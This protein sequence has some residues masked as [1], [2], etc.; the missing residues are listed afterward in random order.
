[1]TGITL[2][3]RS[4]RSV[5]TFVTVDN[6]LQ[7]VFVQTILLQ[8]GY[9]TFV[10]L[11][12]G[13]FCRLFI[14][15]TV[16]ERALLPKPTTTLGLVV[17]AFW[18]VPFLTKWVIAS[19]SKVILARPSWHS[20]AGTFT[21]GTS[22]PRW[23]SLILPHERIRRRIWWWTFPT[24]IDIVAETAIVSFHTLS[25]GFP[26]PTVSKNSL[27][28]LFCSLILD[29]GVLL[30]ISNSAPKILISNFLLHTSLHH[31]F[32]SVI[33][34][35]LTSS[36]ESPGRTIPIRSWVFQTLVFFIC[37]ILPRCHQVGFSS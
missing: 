10:I 24:L 32:Q 1:M 3:I 5:V 15:L 17:Q 37:T 2:D 7:Y 29:H 23:F 35:V 21:S 12:F 27:Y 4:L 8:H 36:D 26:L 14:N 19:S 25:V 22:G 28:T 6:R 33:I 13:P 34:K 16:C 30:K 11:R 20:T 9:C 31:S 18:R